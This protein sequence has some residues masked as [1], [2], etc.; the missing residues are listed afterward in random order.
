ML[1]E[2]MYILVVEQNN[3][4]NWTDKLKVKHFKYDHSCQM[5][6]LFL[7]LYNRKIL[8]KKLKINK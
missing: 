2:W 1:I 8:Y 5:I 6:H 3:Y 7:D 4:L